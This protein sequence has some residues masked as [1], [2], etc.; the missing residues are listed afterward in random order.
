MLKLVTLCPDK[1]VVK[2]LGCSS[3]SKTVR[4]SPKSRWPS[5]NLFIRLCC[6]CRLCTCGQ[7]RHFFRYLVKLIK[8]RLPGV[9]L[10]AEKEN[11][12]EKLKFFESRDLNPKFPNFQ[13]GHRLL[14]LC[15]TDLEA[16][17]HSNFAF[18]LIVRTQG[19]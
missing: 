13:F 7:I 4:Q 15:L 9:I 2:K 16:D 5:Q 1:G 14:G 11:R 3:A 10:A 6:L 12:V 18:L 19:N 8:S 17:E